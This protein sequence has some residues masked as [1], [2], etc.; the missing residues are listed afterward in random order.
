M[1]AGP[2]AMGVLTALEALPSLLLAVFLGVFVDRIRRGR[3][4]FWCNIG[5]GLLIGTVPSA[6]A[7]DLL[8]MMHLYLVT[9][10]V[11]A[12]ALAYGLAHT[13]YIPVLV[14]DRRQLTAANSSIA[15]TDSITAVAGPGIGGLLVQ[16][17]TAPVAIAVDSASFLIA[18]VLQASGRGPDPCRQPRRAGSDCPRARASRRSGASAGSSPSLS[19]REV[20]T[21]STGASSPST[22]S[23]ACESWDC[24]PPRLAR[25]Q[26]WGLSVRC[27]P[28]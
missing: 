1:S 27:W 24:P 3:M 6:A 12:L 4:L 19:A 8:T 23:T 15:L 26:Y 13:A 9:F 20:S 7:F 14:T 5:Q 25:S 22:S 10:S 2:A 28:V 18:A 21:S 16:L 11:S 17:L